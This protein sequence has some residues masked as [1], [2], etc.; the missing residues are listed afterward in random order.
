MPSVVLFSLLALALVG[1]ALAFVLPTL[2]RARVRRQE[3]SRAAVNAD[4]YRRELDELQDEVARGELAAGEA[5]QARADLHRRLVDD[6]QPRPAA[7]LVPRGRRAAVLLVA[8][9]LPL[10][11]A[12]VYLAVGRPDALTAEA[13]LETAG[14]GDYVTRLQSHLSRQ[15][16]DG[17]G[18]VLLARA[19]ADGGEFK[20]AAAS[21][22][23]ALTVSQKI[24]KD[25]GVLCEYADALGMTQGGQL[26]GRPAELVMHA[27]A[28]D[29]KH[30]M[31]LEM[32]GSAAYADG[33]YAEAA[34]YW[35]DLLGQL[36]AGSARREDLASAIARAERKAAVALPR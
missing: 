10:V 4:I 29:P 13:E 14:D 28:L 20:E 31:A 25:P 24:A 27:L 17:R 36:P 6:S 34:R 2:M 8:V 35:K 19:Q 7:T 11:A 33:R 23:K 32:A 9:G 5:Q 18:W 26:A 21:F 12:V 1:V 15:P 22:E 16:R 30:P 3:A